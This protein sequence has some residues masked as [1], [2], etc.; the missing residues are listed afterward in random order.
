MKKSCWINKR[1]IDGECWAYDAGGYES[2]HC[3]LG[4]K[5]K[6]KIPLEKCPKPKNFHEYVKLSRRQY[7]EKIN[8][9]SSLQK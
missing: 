3:K 1:K 4:F 5:M 2:E 8:S 6:N 9:F 7:E